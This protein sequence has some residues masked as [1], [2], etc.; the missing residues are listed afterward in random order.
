[1]LTTRI[2]LFACWIMLVEGLMAAPFGRVIPIGGQASDLAIDE[3]RGV[4]YIANFTANRIEVMSLADGA[5]QT[6]INVAP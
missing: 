1:M 5:I 3:S 4:L 6:S 2:F